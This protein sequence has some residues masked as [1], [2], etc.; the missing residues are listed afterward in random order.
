MDMIAS[1]LFLSWRFDP[2][3][4]LYVGTGKM[5]MT[6]VQTERLLLAMH[7]LLRNAYSLAIGSSYATGDPFKSKV[8]QEC[9][10]SC[11]K[12]AQQCQ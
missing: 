6:C 3:L 12:E 5:T 1:T 10:S 4:K 7:K 9:H 2:L 11:R 8:P